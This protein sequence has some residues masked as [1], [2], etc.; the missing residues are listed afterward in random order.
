MPVSFQPASF[1]PAWFAPAWF[2]RLL[3]GLCACLLAGKAFAAGP[4]EV[5]ISDRSLW[6]DRLDTPAAFDR[7]SRAELLSFGH[8]LLDSEHLDDATLAA[9]LH[10]KQVDHAAVER[11]RERWWQQLARNYALASRDCA[12]DPLFCAP[13]EAAADFRRAAQFFTAAPTSVYA[14]WFADAA[15]FDRVY[16]DELLRLAALFPRT[17]SEVD[18][19][20]AQESQDGGLADRQ[21][22]LSLDDGP[23][24]AG[25]DTDRL[26]AVLRQQHLH[27][28]YFVLGEPLQARARAGSATA[29]AT[30]YADMCVGA[31]GWT[32]TSHS[33]RPDWQDS[34]TN[35]LSLIRH[36]MPDSYVALFRPPYGQRRA[37]SGSFFAGQRVGVLLWNIDSQDWNGKTSAEQV[38]QRVLSLMLLWRHGVILFHDIHAKAQTALPWLLAQTASSGVVWQDCHAVPAPPHG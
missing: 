25:G 21:F 11:L 27:P 36:D 29:L 33:R 35:T 3:C 7:A 15:H 38:R 8:A 26:L 19:Y 10:L 13:P 16:L 28:Q 22:L 14:A 1:R 24:P 37:D 30:L 32:H 31:H 17:S 18:V 23:T 2:R 34:V 5:A 4:S 12:A 6:P 9:R 20:S